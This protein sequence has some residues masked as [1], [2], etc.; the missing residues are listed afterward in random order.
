MQIFLQNSNEKT[1]VH[2]IQPFQ[3]IKDLKYK[4]YSIFKIPI[5]LQRLVFNS[6]ELHN[7][8]SFG[9]YGITSGSNIQLFSKLKGGMG[10]SGSKASLPH[11]VKD[12]QCINSIF[13]AHQR[14][15]RFI[16][17]TPNNQY[18]VTASD[19]FCIGV[20][21]IHKPVRVHIFRDV[22]T[23][24]ITSIKFTHN[25]AYMVSC[26][27]DKSIK[28]YDL[29]RMEIYH[30]FND[31]HKERILCT[32]FS[33]NMKFVLTGSFDRS[34]GIFDVKRK[35][36]CHKIYEAHQSAIMDIQVSDDNRFIIS[37]SLDHTI[38]IF[39]LVKGH[40]ITLIHH[41]SHSGKMV[42]SLSIKLINEPFKVI[43]RSSHSIVKMDIRNKNLPELLYSSYNNLNNIA[44][45]QDFKYLFIL[46]NAKSI[47]I[48]DFE[49]K[50]T[51]YE[52]E[53]EAICSFDITTCGDYIV[54]SYVDR[55]I[56]V[57]KNPLI[58]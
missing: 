30:S 21:Q 6:K 57:F 44:I 5:Y 40:L 16:T 32:V 4:I 2:T 11:D 23:H 19:D 53:I 17:I 50:Q 51:L 41:R 38:K 18:I 33:P 52:M 31:I 54:V 14:L 56:K 8:R 25:S 47:L 24:T 28:I 36:L 49:T 55:S 37:S 43:S 48:I 34:I 22:H 13:N 3:K 1:S 10:A 45:S 42:D 27:S 15:I 20:F 35:R 29:K 58:G 7:N 39:C 26:S 9:D 46:V 12:V